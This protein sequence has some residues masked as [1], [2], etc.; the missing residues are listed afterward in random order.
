MLIMK[1]IEIGS[2]V[3]TTAAAEVHLVAVA[4]AA[5]LILVQELV[6]LHNMVILQDYTLL[7]AVAAAVVDVHG[8]IIMYLLEV[9]VVVPKEDKVVTLMVPTKVVKE[10]DNINFKRI[11]TWLEP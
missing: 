5:L 2:A 1:K 3:D 4:V 6:H 11:Q 7:P 10:V 8:M 9:V